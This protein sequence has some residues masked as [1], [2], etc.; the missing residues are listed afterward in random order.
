MLVIIRRVEDKFNAPRWQAY[1]VTA[2]GEKNLYTGGMW[3]SEVEKNVRSDYPGITIKF[4]QQN[5]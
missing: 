4:I 3:Q 5:F 1:Q 2:D